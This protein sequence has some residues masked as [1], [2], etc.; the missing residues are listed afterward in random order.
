MFER[1]RDTCEEF[2]AVMSISSRLLLAMSVTILSPGVE[3]Q[4][5]LERVLNIFIR[6]NSGGTALSYSDLLLSIA[7]AQWGNLDARAEIH[8]LVDEMNRVG[9][10]F[11]YSK[12]LVLKAGLMLSDIGS[13]GFKVENFNKKNMGLLEA[14]WQRVRES[15]LRAVRLVASFGFNGQNL[16]ADSAILPVAYYIY[17]R[18]LNTAT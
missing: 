8:S 17:W 11:G 16:R 14:N 10:G 3:T 12:D 18:K 2:V 4:Q 1:V 7:V 15:L 6:M 9:D 13:V 5:D